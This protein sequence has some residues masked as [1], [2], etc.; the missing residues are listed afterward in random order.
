MQLITLST[1]DAREWEPVNLVQGISVHSI[2]FFR[3]LFG[4]ISGLVGGRQQMIEEKYLDVRNEALQEIAKRAE[5][6][7]CEAVYGLEVE[8]TELGNNFVVF[9]AAGTAMKRKRTGGRAKPTR[10]AAVRT[11]AAAISKRA[12]MPES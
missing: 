3:S 1:Y 4:S 12:S 7:G 5:A 6:M 10:A 8:T 9:I 2:S 11:R